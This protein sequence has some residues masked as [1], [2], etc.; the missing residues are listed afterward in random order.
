M[1][2]LYGR[3][4]VVVNNKRFALRAVASAAIPAF[5]PFFTVTLPTVV[6]HL[7]HI[8]GSSL[9]GIGKCKGTFLSDAS[10][11]DPLDVRV[12][13]QGASGTASSVGRFDL[14]V[15]RAVA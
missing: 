1:N 12:I 2:V 13:D 5:K 14:R 15:G 3:V 10:D 6:P 8:P 7:S 11:L 9:R 4:S